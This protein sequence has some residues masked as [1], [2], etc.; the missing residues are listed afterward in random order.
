MF[1]M[2]NPAE[3]TPER[4]MQFGFAYAPPLII[5]AAANNKVF[6]TIAGGSK[7]VEEISRATGASVRGL[8]AIMNALVGLELLK[9]N[10]D[11]YAL[12]P[13]S[14]AFLV[15]GKPGSL[16]GFFGMASTH[17]IPHW[18]QLT[19]AVKT[20]RPPAALNQEKTGAEFFSVLVENIIPMSYPA[21]VALGNA[22]DLSSARAPVRVL[23]IAAGSGIWGIALAQQ[24]A[25]VLV[26]AQDWPEMIPTTRRIVERFGVAD[27]FSYLAGDVLEADFGSGYDIATLGHIL[28]TEGEERSRHLLRKTFDALKS[29]GTIAIGEWLVNDERTEPMNGLIFAVNMLVHSEQGD[30]FS[31]NE[32]KSWLEEAGFKKARTLDAPGPSPLILAIKP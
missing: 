21:A 25:Q 3:V 27:R 1:S 9:K 32:I 22:L 16:A 15:S 20:G 10:G 7:T 4:L 2:P 6:D 14:D 12:T 17:I 19:D 13:E 24:S 18:L 23:D 30:T 29:G 11:K 31:F 5:G 8:R 28:H 26:T